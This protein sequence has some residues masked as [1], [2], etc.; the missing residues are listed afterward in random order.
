MRTNIKEANM[1]TLAGIITALALAGPAAASELGGHWFDAGVIFYGQDVVSRDRGGAK[2]EIRLNLAPE[3]PDAALYLGLG[4]GKGSWKQEPVSRGNQYNLVMTDQT[5]LDFGPGISWK[6]TTHF[7]AGVMLVGYDTRV[8]RH[9]NGAD[10]NNFT[11]KASGSLMGGYGAVGV[12]LPIGHWLVPLMVGYRETKG[13][14]AVNLSN[15]SV[16]HVKPIKGP[17]VSVGLRMRF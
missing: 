2:A 8:V 3:E 13:D 5:W 11:D 1:R 14:T 4:V 15:G 12:E 10:Y 6:K 16:I 7:E 17:Y 9:L